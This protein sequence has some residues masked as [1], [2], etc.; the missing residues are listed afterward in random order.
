MSQMVDQPDLAFDLFDRLHKSM[1]ISGH[2]ATSLAAALEVHRNTVNNYLKGKTPM[3]RRSKIAWAFATGV[4]LVWLETGEAETSTTPE[5][6][7]D[8]TTAITAATALYPRSLRDMDLAR[9][10]AVDAA[11]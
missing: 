11:A 9:L 6:P 4:P 3:D 10:T 1:R 7:D 5:P 8:G 2:T